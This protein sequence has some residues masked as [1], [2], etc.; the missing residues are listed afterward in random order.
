M[1]LKEED[2]YDIAAILPIDLTKTYNILIEYLA[3]V[4][5]KFLIFDEY[6]NCEEWTHNYSQNGYGAGGNNVPHVH[7]IKNGES[8]VY[9]NITFD[10][11]HLDKLVYPS[12]VIQ[13]VLEEFIFEP[14]DKITQQKIK[15][16]ISKIFPESTIVCDNT[17]NPS[18]VVDNHQLN[19]TVKIGEVFY[20][21]TL[22]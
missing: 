18:S 1:K 12:T 11:I 4:F 19:A 16:R 9:K 14:N 10:I 3:G 5:I 15:N 20:N 13:N 7:L 21:Y 8:F 6:H 2:Y 17:N 22:G